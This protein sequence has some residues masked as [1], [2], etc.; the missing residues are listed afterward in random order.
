MEV[1]LVLLILSLLFFASIF[2]D[3]IGYRLGVPALLL[4]LAVGMIFGPDGVGRA[5]ASAHGSTAVL[6]IGAA[7]A[8]GTISLCVILFSGGLDTKMADIQL[9][10]APGITLATLGVLLTAT[11]TG[12]LLYFIAGWFHAAAGLSIWMALLIASTMSSTDSASVFSILRTNGVRLKHN[13]RPLLELESG[14]N[15]PMA[16]ILTVTLIGVVTG[17]AKVSAVYIIQ[18]V[19][20]QLVMGAVIGFAFGKVVVELLKRTRFTNDALYPIMVFSA[21]IFIFAV[22]YYLA[23]NPYLAV[24]IGGLIIGNSKFTKKRQ[25]KSFFNALSWLCQLLMFLMLGLMVHPHELLRPAVW[26][27]GIFIS[28]VMI[29]FARPLSVILCMLP[30]NKQFHQRDRLFLSWVGLK[31]AV[32]IIFAILCMANDVPHAG[33]LFNV[34]FFCTLL[35]LLVQGTSINWLAGKLKLSLPAEEEHRLVYFDIDLP[36]DVES[37][38]WES[39]VTENL[40]ANGDR[41]MDIVIPKHTLVIMVRRGDNFFVPRGDTQLQVGDQLLIISDNNASKVVQEIEDEEEHI[42]EHW[43]LLLLHHTG[44]F[45]RSGWKRVLEKVRRERGRRDQGPSTKGRSTKYQVPSTE[46]NNTEENKTEA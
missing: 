28:V 16:Y 42:L 34:V 25:T 29:F 21:C 15:D 37:S 8:I 20:V 22:T 43:G 26:M 27:S 23:G 19:A 36:E 4:F 41:L 18:T 12:V 40:L 46:V 14:A 6:S 44:V 38:A 9:V 32:P 33:F 13:L 1:E 3:K 7:Q 10:M 11:F 30:Y 2:T 5:L 39:Q 45:A 31:G 35:S 17:G 24:Y